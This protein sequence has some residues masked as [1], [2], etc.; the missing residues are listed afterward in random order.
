MGIV[1]VGG[2]RL[3]GNSRPAAE[4]APGQPPRKVQTSRY[5]YHW[6][7]DTSLQKLALNKKPGA[8][9]PLKRVRKMHVLGRCFPEFM[10]RRGLFAWTN[11]VTAMGT[12]GRGSDQEMYARDVNDP[13]ARPALVRM[14]IDPNARALEI[15]STNGLYGRER[16]FG[17]LTEGDLGDA[18]LILHKIYCGDELRFQEWIILDPSIVQAFTANPADLRPELERCLAQIENPKHA[19]REKDL[20]CLRGGLFHEGQLNDRYTTEVFGI[21]REFLASR[22]EDIPDFFD[23][24]QGDVFERTSS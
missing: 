16:K 18:Q 7:T 22:D 13:N 21:V 17:R 6:T 14:T 11:P 23:H 1:R 2:V 8:P 9:M 19:F 3:A 15:K 12:G 4:V 5:L 24:G 10:R 20:Y